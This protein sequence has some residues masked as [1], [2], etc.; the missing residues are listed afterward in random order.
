MIFENWI[1]LLGDQLL[2]E[3]VS[4]LSDQTRIAEKLQAEL[5]RNCGGEIKDPPEIYFVISDWRPILLRT[6]SHTILQISSFLG[7]LDIVRPLFDSVVVFVS[8]LKQV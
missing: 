6:E 4:S 5:L 7:V 3:Q 2:A 1:K 8:I